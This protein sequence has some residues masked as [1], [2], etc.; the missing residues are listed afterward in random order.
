MSANGVSDAIGITFR[1]AGRRSQRPA[2]VSAQIVKIRRTR[3]D[4]RESEQAW[5]G[6]SGIESVLL[7]IDVR[8]QW[9]NGFVE[10]VVAEASRVNPC[11]IRNPRP[12]SAKNLGYRG[13]VR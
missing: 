4:A 1:V 10:T 3:V 7:W 2:G 11:R 9:S 6:D 13:C 8:I 5:V 12:I